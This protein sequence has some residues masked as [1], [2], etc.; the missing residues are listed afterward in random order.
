MRLL[1]LG[2]TGGTGRAL[3][4]QARTRSHQVTA[5]VRSPKKLGAPRD[6]V[7]VRRGDPLDAVQVRDVLAG[8]DA[9]LS[10]L[11]AP[12]PGRTTILRD[13]SRVIVDAMR[14]AG[15]RR[16]LVVSAAILFDGIGFF[17]AVMRRTLLRNIFT[18][19]AAMERT[20][21]SSDL[22]WTIARPPRLTNGPLTKRYRVADGRM[23]PG[24]L[25]VSRADVADFLLD[26]VEEKRHVHAIVGIAAVR[27][28]APS[29]SGEPVW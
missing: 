8:H 25:T 16:L 20:I 18:D 28:D 24:K 13:S 26:E 14:D 21:A 5:F 23:P 2:A 27:G 7:I 15:V 9:V 17:P 10:A 4:D 3:I 6:G 11:G 29:T 19:A 22:E 1:I 12:G